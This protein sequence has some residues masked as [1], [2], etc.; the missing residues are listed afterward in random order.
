MVTI[1]DGFGEF[2]RFERI[3]QTD[4]TVVSGFFLL[5]QTFPLPHATAATLVINFRFRIILDLYSIFSL[6]LLSVSSLETNQFSQILF[7][8]AAATLVPHLGMNRLIQQRMHPTIIDSPE[9][10][11]VAAKLLQVVVEVVWAA[12][13][14]TCENTYLLK[15]SH[16]HSFDLSSVVFIFRIFNSVV[17]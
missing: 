13:L 11:L 4:S 12:R 7:F 1:N 6:L 10:R 8:L 9:F 3:R 15:Y 2:F 16:L 5:F 14:G 17:W